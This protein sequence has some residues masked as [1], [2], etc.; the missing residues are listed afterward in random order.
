VAVRSWDR[1]VP[2]TVVGRRTLARVLTAPAESWDDG[3]CAMSGPVAG[4]TALEGPSGLDALT[5]RTAY[6]PVEAASAYAPEVL[7]PTRVTP[8]RP[9]T[10]PPEETAHR[11]GETTD[12]L[13]QHHLRQGRSRR[14]RPPLPDAPSSTTEIPGREW[15]SLPGVQ[16]RALTP[17]GR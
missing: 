4:R 16:A 9:A 1:G 11:L 17:R 6:V 12:R 14:A 2:T 10:C 7:E 5:G 13:L 3:Q 15:R 8:G